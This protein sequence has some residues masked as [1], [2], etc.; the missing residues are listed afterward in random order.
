MG[1]LSGNGATRVSTI[2][3][4]HVEI[5]LNKY[6]LQARICL[7]RWGMNGSGVSRSDRACAG[8]RA[9]G[10][11]TLP[12]S[13]RKPKGSLNHSRMPIAAVGVTIV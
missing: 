6:K 11:P 2:R 13:E 3:L 7:M 9:K 5:G 12:I 4:H 8:S 10:A 1:G